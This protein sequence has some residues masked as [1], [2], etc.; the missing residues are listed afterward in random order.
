MDLRRL[1]LP[2]LP[3]LALVAVACFSDPVFPGE[4]VLGTFRFDAT[5]DRSRTTCTGQTGDPV[6]LGDAGVL[7]FTGTFSS[8]GDGGTGFLTVQDFSRSAEYEGQRAVSRHRVAATFQS[9]GTGCEGSQIEE[10]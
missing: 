3:V 1:F 4:Q 6:Q 8:R 10:T 5:L 7:R 2:S 9:C